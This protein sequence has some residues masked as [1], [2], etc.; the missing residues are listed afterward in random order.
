[1]DKSYYFNEVFNL[2]LAYDGSTGLEEIDI[3]TID[4]EA[5]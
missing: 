5:L 1:M 4:Q 3:N 2:T